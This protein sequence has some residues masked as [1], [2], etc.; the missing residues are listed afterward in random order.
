MWVG[1]KK[2]KVLIVDEATLFNGAQ[3][4][5]LSEIALRENGII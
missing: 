3:L 5:A 4:Q 2:R 1:K